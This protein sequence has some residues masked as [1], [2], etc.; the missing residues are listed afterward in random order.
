MPQR[1]LTILRPPDLP[2]SDDPAEIKKYNAR[3]NRYHFNVAVCVMALMILSGW[4]ASPFG[5]ARAGDIKP[6]IDE[7][8]KPV[9]DEINKLEQ[10]VIAVTKSQETNT[11][12][13]AISLANSTAG[14]I[15]LL[16]AKRCKERGPTGNA[17]ERERLTREIERKQDEY[18]E[19]RGSHYQIP[20]CEDL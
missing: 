15:R 4:A 9:K 8:L 18:Y 1:L 10:A 11:R 17:N 20:N 16:A 6:Q 5:F 2:Q 7:A 13:L 14:E 19:L 12:R 3:V